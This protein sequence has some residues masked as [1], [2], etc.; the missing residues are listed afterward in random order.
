MRKKALIW[1][2]F[3]GGLF[4]FSIFFLPEQSGLRSLV[5]PTSKIEQ[6]VFSL[7]IGLGVLNLLRAHF[8]RIT[9]RRPGYYNSIVLS[10]G[11]FLMAFAEI[12]L[13]YSRKTPIAP[14][15]QFPSSTFTTIFEMQRILFKSIF[16]GLN[17]TIFAL[18]AFYMASAA[19]RA[20]RIKSMEAGIMMVVAVLVMLGQI[21]F[22]A[23]V[24]TSG[25]P[26][27][28]WFANFRLE[29]IRG[30]IMDYWNTAA[31]RGIMFGI[32]IGSLAMT[33][34]IWLSLEAGSFFEDV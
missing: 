24:I 19:Y 20:F 15:D 31:Y 23:G 34:R 17:S 14:G 25:I 18:L 4:Y 5:S 2:T 22:G 29:T 10:L 33:M 1:V 32:F 28:S 27:D 11:L 13:Y 12:F 6:V 7:I 3:I 30:W 26:A 8:N 9:L 21:S 16:M